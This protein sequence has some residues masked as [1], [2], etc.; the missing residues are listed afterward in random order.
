MTEE[1]DIDGLAAEYVLGSLDAGERKEVAARRR[2]DAAL[3]RAIKAW[4][5]RL[6][7]LSEGVPD[8]EPP[9]YVFQRV[10]DRLSAGR[11]L[12]NRPTRVRRALV[13][14]AC[15]LAACLVLAVIWLRDLPTIPATLMAHLQR[16]GAATVLDEGPNVWTPFR[17]E[18]L[19]DLRAS[20]M[21]VSPVAAAASPSPHYQ[22][23][24]LPRDSGPP[25]SLGMIAL[26]AHHHAALAG[27][28]PSQQSPRGDACRQSRA[29]GRI[30]DR[31]AIR[32]AGVCRQAFQDR[33]P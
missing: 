15:A 8:L 13:A 11:G 7:P 16:S 4:E 27:D 33:D 23:W 24:L 1:D 6:G 17:F 10:T 2:T 14:G 22:L 5:K 30:D 28:L 31:H 26:P 9:P 3:D 18:V 29:G 19:F 32:P 12:S 25:I 21:I 20:T